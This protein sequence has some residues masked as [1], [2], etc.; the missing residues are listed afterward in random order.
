MKPVKK[1]TIVIVDDE[2]GLY[3]EVSKILKKELNINVE[4]ID[5]N[6]ASVKRDS[7]THLYNRVKLYEDCNKDN[8]KIL[9]LIDIIGFSRINE[10]YGHNTGDMVLK[11]LAAF[12][13]TM[14][15]DEFNVYHLESDLFALVAIA[16]TV[17]NIFEK[18]ENIKDDIIQLNIITNKFNQNLDISIGV[19]HQKDKSILRKAEL[20]LKEARSLG[21]NKIKYYSEDLKV[22]KK[23]NNIN[24]WAPIIKDSINEGN[25]LV[26]YQPIYDL[27]TNRVEKY[28]LLMRI[29]HEGKVHLPAE[30]L[31][32]A[33]H[34]GQTYEIF[35][36]M[37]RAA[38]IQVQKT[39]LKFSV[40]IGDADL[41]HEEVLDF[42]T[43]SIKTYNINPSLLSVEILEYN[44]ISTNAEI[45]ERIIK[46]H[47]LGIGIVIDDFGVN[48]SNFGQMQ[49]LPIDI[50]KID[51]SFI[52]N[53]LDSKN[54]QIVVKTIQ[55]FAKEKNI[56]LVAEY[57]SSKD[58]WNIVKA[59]GIEYGQGFYLGEPKSSIEL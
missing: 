13:Y 17:Q 32:V 29:K 1:R 4:L 23:F 47:E 33:Y 35:K 59:L 26:Y 5:S 27:S 15:H 38:C 2:Q 25:I 3:P 53:I 55:T 8:E 6:N 40:N 10:N 49:N 37:F 54:S 16:D 31:D 57:V 39:G 50:I 51:G 19:A 11:E 45:K 58:V 46:I 56:K 9:I 22:L 48:C 28:E 18:V 43:D 21:L 41:A 36:Q 24:Y 44:A 14:Y 30:F 12:L 42:I 34:T 20:A 7:L 52:S